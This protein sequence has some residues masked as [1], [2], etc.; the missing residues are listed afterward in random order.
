VSFSVAWTSE[1]VAGL[2]CSDSCNGHVSSAMYVA[3]CSQDINWVCLSR[4]MVTPG[5]GVG[6]PACT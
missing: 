2:M 3:C 1:A 4:L 5:A 6:L